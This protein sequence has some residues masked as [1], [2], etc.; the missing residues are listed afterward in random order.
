MTLERDVIEFHRATHE[1]NL[2][3]VES[4][5]ESSD[6]EEDQELVF[7]FFCPIFRCV[8]AVL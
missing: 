2:E 6:G 3:E 1:A 5:E 7:V 4:F 8:S